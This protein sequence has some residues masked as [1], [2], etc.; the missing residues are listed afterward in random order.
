MTQYFAW[1]ID[2]GKPLT[3]WNYDIV[4]KFESRH[5]GRLLCELVDNENYMASTVLDFII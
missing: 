1:V 3:N 4:C 5:I 2:Y